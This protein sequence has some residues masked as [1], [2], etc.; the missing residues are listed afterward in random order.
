MQKPYIVLEKVLILLNKFSMIKYIT[1]LV[2]RKNPTINKSLNSLRASWITDKVYIY[3]E[4]WTYNIDDSNYELLM[5]ETKK[6]CFINFDY[7]IKQSIDSDYIFTFQDDYIFRQW[8]K[9]EIERIIESK[10]DFLYYNFILDY[11]VAD[12]IFKEWWNNT[13]WGWSNIWAC[14][15]FKD[16][17]KII[18]H[19]FYKNHLSDYAPKRNQQIDSCIGQVWKELWSPCYIPSYSYVAHIWESTI[20]HKDDKLW[21]FFKKI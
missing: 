14:F 5:N 11:R 4:P 19:S 18:N 9:E 1:T 16:I 20:W 17:K 6:G 21:V 12:K 7:S 2:E 3:A 8:I 10:E 15:L 13:G